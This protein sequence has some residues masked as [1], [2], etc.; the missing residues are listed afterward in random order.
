MLASRAK[1]VLKKDKKNRKRREQRKRAQSRRS[2]AAGQPDHLEGYLEEHALQNHGSHSVDCS[3]EPE[4]TVSQVGLTTHSADQKSAETHPQSTP[5][6]ALQA[7]PKPDAKQELEVK[8]DSDLQPE[9]E[10]AGVEPQAEP[11][12][13][14]PLAG[15]MAE[16]DE[17]Q[18]QIQLVISHFPH[19]TQSECSSSSSA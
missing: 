17:A 18:V 15:P 16:F 9:R 12:E 14:P 10:E 7:E 6:T 1:D 3:A 11:E 13:K 19:C 2:T 4:A 5:E 8:T